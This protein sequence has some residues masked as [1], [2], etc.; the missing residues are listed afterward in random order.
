MR[1]TL[2]LIIVA[3]LFTVGCD[4]R[5]ALTDGG[6]VTM[7][8]SDFDGLPVVVSVNDATSPPTDA[9]D[10]DANGFVTI[11]S[12][13]I[14]SIVKD[15]TGNTSDLQNVEMDSYEVSY[16]RVDGG[17]LA[18]PP[19]VRKVFGVTPVGGTQ[20]YDNLPVLSP[21]QFDQPPLSDL[22]FENGGFD[23][24]TGAEMISLNLGLR[25]FGR[26]VSGQEVDSQTAQFTVDFVP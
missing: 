20:I 10:G 25:F 8:I 22:L 23:S 18:P 15:Q 3:M 17:S 4:S 7:S 11:S 19:L 16:R 14:Q 13:T 21:D 5:T 12:V 2:F 24:E 6:G 9:D 1:R 26:T